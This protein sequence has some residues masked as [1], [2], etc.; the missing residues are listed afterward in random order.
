MITPCMLVL[1]ETVE[2]LGKAS[3]VR[4]LGHVFRSDEND[5]LRKVLSFK[6]DGQR[7]QGQPWKI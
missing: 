5:T 4:W 6:V 1:R 2:N 7:K 3:R